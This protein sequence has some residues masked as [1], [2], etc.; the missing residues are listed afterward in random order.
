MAVGDWEAAQ[1]S[2]NQALVLAPDEASIL[3]RSAVPAMKAMDFQSA[4]SR[5]SKAHGIDAD[6]ALATRLHTMLTPVLTR[7]VFLQK[8]LEGVLDG[9]PIPDSTSKDELLALAQRMSWWVMVVDLLSEQPEPSLSSFDLQ[10]TL[11]FAAA[12]CGAGLGKGSEA[13]SK[14]QR[15]QYRGQALNAFSQALSIYEARAESAGLTKEQRARLRSF[16]TEP[17]L[18]PYRED[19]KGL[20]FPER[21]LWA[22]LW[23]RWHRLISKE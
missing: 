19:M 13:L 12:H 17:G 3:A 4:L 9:Q 15:A 22:Q 7:G 11:L 21:L 14:E 2:Y 16:N 8:A 1:A 23:D 5:L 20:E 18:L 6:D 10:E